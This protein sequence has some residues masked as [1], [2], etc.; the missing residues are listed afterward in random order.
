MMMV[1]IDKN[2]KG[3]MMVKN[4]LNQLNVVVKIGTVQK[5]DKILNKPNCEK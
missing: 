1:K 3:T 2:R 4:I 5:I